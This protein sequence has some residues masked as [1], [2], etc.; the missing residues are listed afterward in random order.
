MLKEL[1]E[2]MQLSE[3]IDKVKNEHYQ[4]TS[5][6]KAD[7]APEAKK[8]AGATFSINH[9]KCVY[10]EAKMT[11]DRPGAFLAIW[12]R[13]DI[14]MKTKP[15][16]LDAS[17]LD[18]LF[19]G[20]E[21][22]NNKQKGFFIFPVLLLLHKNIMSSDN[23]KGKTGFRVFPPWAADRGNIGTQVFSASG[24]KTQHWQLPYFVKMNEDGSLDPSKFN[25]IF[26][27]L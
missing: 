9:K 1:V 23:K 22:I 6:E 26:H 19:I 12:K 24:K 16:P 10:R 20:V 25:Q 13:L 2:S 14:Q 7:P 27:T 3:L 18:Y 5:T 21:N 4:I 17:D 11:P 15:I 8:Y